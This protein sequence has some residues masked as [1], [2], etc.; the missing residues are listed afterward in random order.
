TVVVVVVASSFSSMD[1][2]DFKVVLSCLRR[3]VDVP[4][5]FLLFKEEAAAAA[6][7]LE[8][9]AQNLAVSVGTFKVDSSSGSMAV[10][11]RAS[12]PVA[13]AP[14][15]AA[16]VAKAAPKALAKPG[17]KQQGG[18]DDEDWEEF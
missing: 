2:F 16:P 11:R 8:E 5:A 17:A 7:S 4:E 13:R 15:H 18:G 1:C 3:F 9:Q 14:Q 10:A 6:E 12:A